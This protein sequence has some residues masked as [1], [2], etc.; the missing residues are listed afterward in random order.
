MSDVPI[1]STQDND[2]DTS[3]GEDLTREPGLDQPR[4]V[5][6]APYDRVRAHDRVRAGIAGGLIL[7]V[8]ALTITSYVAVLASDRSLDDI[9]KLH[10]IVV[11]PL[12][13]MTGGII[14]FYFAQRDKS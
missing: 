5:D 14:G 4:I 3:P 10:G 13:T 9:A 8:A 12:L 6:F 11:A 1:P 2:S 7:L